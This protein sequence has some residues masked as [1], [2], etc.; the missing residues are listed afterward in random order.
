VSRKS[1]CKDRSSLGSI[2]RFVSALQLDLVCDRDTVRP[3]GARSLVENGRTED[4]RPLDESE[5]EEHAFSGRGAC[6][7]QVAAHLSAEVRAVL[8]NTDLPRREGPSWSMPN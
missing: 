7:R 4:R 5:H 8:A 6:A 3:R 1:V 2:S